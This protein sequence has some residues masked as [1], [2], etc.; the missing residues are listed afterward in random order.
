VT[1]GFNNGVPW[2]GSPGVSGGGPDTLSAWLAVNQQMGGTVRRS[3][4][5]GLPAS[6]NL[7]PAGQDAANGVTP[8]WSVKPPG[9][10][11]AGMASG[12]YDSQIA[13][14]VA[15][16]PDNSYGTVWHEPEDDMTGPEWVAMFTRFYNVAKSV[17]PTLKLGHAAMEYQ[18]DIFLKSTGNVT[19]NPELW[20]PG[21]NNIDFLGVDVYGEDWHAGH[22]AKPLMNFNGFNRWY[23]YASSHSKPLV[24][25]EISIVLTRRQAGGGDPY[26]GT[27]LGSYTDTERAN[28]ITREIGWLVATGRFDLITWWHNEWYDAGGGGGS[29]VN[30]LA[31][32]PVGNQSPLALA[33]WNA[34]ARPGG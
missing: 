27:L 25:A 2:S 18:W 30:S 34:F 6:F 28:W 13:A 26:S 14:F 12:A 22:P 10:D 3:F 7:H 32:A 33:A 17:N 4:T 15:G 20:Y 5:S 19:T 8:F 29:F 23:T 24:V 9:G 1:F 16:A 21:D 31:G 11:H